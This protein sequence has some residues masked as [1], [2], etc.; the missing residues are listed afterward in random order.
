MD[1]YKP[2]YSLS[3]KLLFSRHLIKTYIVKKAFFLWDKLIRSGE[4]ATPFEVTH[5]NAHSDKE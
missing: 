1:I 3:H 4:L 5:I 2:I